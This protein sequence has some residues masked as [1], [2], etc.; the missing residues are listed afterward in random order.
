MQI[1]TQVNIYSNASAGIVEEE[2]R[3]EDAKWRKILVVA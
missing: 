1:N 2:G 3:L